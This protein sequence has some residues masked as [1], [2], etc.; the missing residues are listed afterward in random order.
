[1][2]RWATELALLG[3]TLVFISGAFAGYFYA[4][5]ASHID[6][7][8]VPG[9]STG[10]TTKVMVPASP[11]S[12]SARDVACKGIVSFAKDAVHRQ[13]GGREQWADG[14]AAVFG[15]D[16]IEWVNSPK[17]TAKGDPLTWNLTIT[18]NGLSLTVQPEVIK[19]LLERAKP[20]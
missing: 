19:C 5:L 12:T 13:T 1:M 8:P 10:D 18:L 7:L 17:A 11:G 6:A 9:V 16:R 2:K 20:L 15:A 4:G 3:V 14:Y